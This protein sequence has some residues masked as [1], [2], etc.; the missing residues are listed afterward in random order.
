MHLW[1]YVGRRILLLVPVFLLVTFLTF[2]ITYLTPSSPVE[3]L[4]GPNATPEQVQNLYRDLGLD[5]PFLVQYG[6]W[7]FRMVRGDLGISLRSRRPVSEDIARYF[8]ATLELTIVSMC[9]V[10]LLGIVMGAV[11]AVRRNTWLDHFT[12][13]M[14]L[15]GVAAPI[16][17]IGLL[18]QLLFYSTW[19]VLP[20]GGRAET[21]TLIRFPIQPITGLYLVDSL[22]QGNWPALKSALVHLILPTVT[23]SMR[24][25]ALV[26]RM[27]RSSLLDVLTQDFIRTARSMG[28]AERTVVLRYALKNAMLP[29]VTV[30]TL[31]FGKLLGGTFLVETVFDWPGMGLYALQSI[32]AND[33]SAILG[34]SM[35]LTVGYMLGNTAADILYARMDPRVRY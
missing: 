28:F 10:I 23:L 29:V 22:L 7:V 8:A 17:W 13:I 15:V 24:S 33:Y 18:L 3:L 12:R 4:L 34:V 14:A 25:L 27:V 30:I 2:L 19:H 9:A 31:E 5:R 35:V 21:F 26:M 6:R 11:S 16:F 1:A 32:T 20:V